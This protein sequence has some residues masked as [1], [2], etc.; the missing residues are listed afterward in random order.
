MAKPPRFPWI[1]GIQPGYRA[2]HLQ[3]AICQDD[4]HNVWAYSDLADDTDHQTCHTLPSHGVEQIAF[5]L[6]CEAVRREAYLQVLVHLSADPEFLRGYTA[7]SEDGKAKMIATLGQVAAKSLHESV[8]RM[9]S[10]ACAEV[11]AMLSD[12]PAGLPH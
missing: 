3:V 7:A 12:K 11:L 9:T 1:K 4:D 10:D 8:D 6:L 2:F 5:G